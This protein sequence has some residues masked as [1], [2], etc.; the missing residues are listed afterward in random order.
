MGHIKTFLQKVIFVREIYAMR[1]RK[2]VPPSCRV[3]M[4]FVETANRLPFF[5]SFFFLS[6]LSCGGSLL[7]VYGGKGGQRAGIDTTALPFVHGTNNK[8]ALPELQIANGAT[9]PKKLGTRFVVLFASARRLGGGGRPTPAPHSNDEIGK[10]I[11]R[12]G[13]DETADWPH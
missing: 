7:V 1:T 2:F 13:T 8:S 10:P 3:R 9:L 11:L 12:L 5:L 4:S 6:S